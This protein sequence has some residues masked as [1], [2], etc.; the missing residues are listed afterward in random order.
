MPPT[1]ATHPTPQTAAVNSVTHPPS[2]AKPAASMST[3]MAIAVIRPS[4]QLTPPAISVAPT[5]KSRMPVTTFMTG[6][7]S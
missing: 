3:A 6:R 1:S 4:G 5:A 2:A 7:P